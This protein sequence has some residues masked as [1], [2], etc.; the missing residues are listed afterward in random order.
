[1]DLLG[2]DL[3]SLLLRPLD[4]WVTEALAR[5][6]WSPGAIEAALRLLRVAAA[7]VLAC[8]LAGGGLALQRAA[9]AGN[10]TGRGGRCVLQ[11]ALA[12]IGVAAAGLF[13][14][15]IC[16]PSSDIATLIG[17]LD[18]LVFCALAGCVLGRLPILVRKWA[19][20][21]GSICILGQ[22]AG[23]TPVGIVLA[24]ALLGFAALRVGLWKGLWATVSVQAAILVGTFLTAWM[25]R[26]STPLTALS[27]QGLFAFVLLRHLSFVVE[28]RRGIP[29][30]LAD[31]LC[32]MAFYPSCL[33]ASEVY[34][35]FYDRN[36]M[37]P[38]RYDYR[39]AVRFVVSGGVQIWAALLLPV[40]FDTTVRLEHTA[41]LWLTV[42]LLFI[43]SALFIMGLW[44]VITACA[45]FHGIE[46]RP[47]FAGILRCENPSQFWHAWRGT[48]TRWL[49]QYVYIPL[50]GNR[51]RQTR[52]IAAAF[53]AS[54]LWHCMGV[55]FISPH[56][57]GRNF[58]PV[59]LWGAFNAAGVMA[60]AAL[61]RRDWSSLSQPVP[62]PLRR[63]TKILL[64]ACFGTFTVTLLGFSPTTIDYF[65]SFL[66]TLAGLQ[67]W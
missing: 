43:R 56:V 23:W 6:S 58:A 11:F 26:S 61:R 50:G 22:H 17:R 19:L 38:G 42:L 59:I 41:T 34:N 9:E 12:A 4:H 5:A 35:E 64:T 65:G 24:A 52:N 51:R 27:T 63:A 31:Y 40:S 3:F 7:S 1:M 53:A 16:R 62:A 32:Y 67:T 14:W 45:C 30:E 15:I 49:I 46:L 13:G 36:L 60:Y 28:A 55:P 39:G 54:T 25:L 8:L 47:N 2:P 48:M 44:A 57:V 66:R 10:E 20:T 18:H 37:G 21:A 29:G 33:G